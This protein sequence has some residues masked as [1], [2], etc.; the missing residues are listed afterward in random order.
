MLLSSNKII[1]SREHCLREVASNNFYIFRAT[2]F[3]ATVFEVFLEWSAMLAIP[4]ERV[5]GT[6]HHLKSLNQK[7]HTQQDFKIVCKN[8]ASL[9]ELNYHWFEPFIWLYWRNENNLCYTKTQTKQIKSHVFLLFL[10]YSF[11]KTSLRPTR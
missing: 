8:I 11:G 7:T 6:V 1:L 3:A 2:K 4:T 10:A 5:Y 9:T